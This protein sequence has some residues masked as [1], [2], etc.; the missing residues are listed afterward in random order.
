MLNFS[1]VRS[2]TTCAIIR[3]PFNRGRMDV[4]KRTGILL[5]AFQIDGVGGPA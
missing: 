1:K 3:S 4:R 5:S 2:Q